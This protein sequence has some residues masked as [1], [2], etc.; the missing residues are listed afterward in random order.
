MSSEIDIVEAAD[1]VNLTEGNISRTA[2]GDRL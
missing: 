1:V 2:K